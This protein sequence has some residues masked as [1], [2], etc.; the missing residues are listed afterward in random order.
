MNLATG[1][2]EKGEYTP[3]SFEQPGRQKQFARLEARWKRKD[4]KVITTEISGRPVRDERGNLLYF[5]VIAE[6]VS[7]LRGVEQRLRHVQKMEA[8][9][10]L[11][12]GIAH[13]FNNVLG[14]YIRIFRNAG[15]QIEGRCGTFSAARVH[16]QSRG[17]GRSADQAASGLQPSASFATA[18]HFSRRSHGQDQGNACAGHRRRHSTFNREKN[19][20]LRVKVDPT[21]LEQVVMNLVVNARDAMPNG[22]RLS[23]EAGEI[24]IDEEYCSRNPGLASRASRNGRCDRYRSR[25]ERRCSSATFR[26][27]PLPPKSK[28]GA[29]AW[30]WQRSTAS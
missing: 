5:E 11:A 9:G 27:V 10:R 3:L 4:G 22:G 24:E 21:Q 25:N 7:H 14:G 28:A 26:A 17:K 19:T 16:L 23:I 30:G 6:D 1:V 20:D 8:I 29:P 12:G 2:F 15:G 18:N 13:D